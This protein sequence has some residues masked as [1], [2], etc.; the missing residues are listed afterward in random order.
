[1][2]TKHKIIVTLL[3]SLLLLVG[4][5]SDYESKVNELESLVDTFYS[6]TERNILPYW[7]VTYIP[8]AGWTK[9]VLVF[10]YGDNE[11]VCREEIL[12]GMQSAAPA[13]EFDCAASER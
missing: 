7:I 9:T 11:G 3:L 8:D 6:E 12:P 10:G 1:M 5:S 4:C 2:I 13:R